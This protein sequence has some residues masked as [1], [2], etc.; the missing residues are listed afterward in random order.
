MKLMI[1]F[2]FYVW[3]SDR[4]QRWLHC[5]RLEPTPGCFLRGCDK[6][7]LH[8][9]SLFTQSLTQQH[10]GGSL[11]YKG[12]GKHWKIKV[13]YPAHI[14]ILWNF[15]FWKSCTLCI[16]RPVSCTAA[17]QDALFFDWKIESWLQDD[18]LSSNPFILTGL[19]EYNN[20]SLPELV[21]VLEV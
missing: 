18:P 14:V 19:R 8:L 9:C 17:S 21:V 1:K 15:L 3:G 7:D 2:I 20:N 5:R 12:H 6:M 13:L 10:T 11:F 16:L 4:C